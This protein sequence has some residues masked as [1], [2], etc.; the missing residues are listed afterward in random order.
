MKEKT[1]AEKLEEIRSFWEEQIQGWQESGLP[2]V[3]F[4]GKI[5]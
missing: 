3:E 1:R 5:I 2:Q 4:S